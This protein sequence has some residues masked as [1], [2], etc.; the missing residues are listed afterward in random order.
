MRQYRFR[1]KTFVW[2]LILSM[3]LLILPGCGETPPVVVDETPPPSQSTAPEETSDPPEATQ[4]AKTTPKPGP[5]R[6]LNGNRGWRVFQLVNAQV[7]PLLKG[8]SSSS[9]FLWLSVTYEA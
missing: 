4:P 5:P 2:A 1:T 6:D 8:V 7:I 9:C 3:I